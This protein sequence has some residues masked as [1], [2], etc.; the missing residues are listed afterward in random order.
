MTFSA[1]DIPYGFRRLRH[2][3]GFSLFSRMRATWST[4][5]QTVVTFGEAVTGN[6]F[7]VLGVRPPIT[8]RPRTSARGDSPHVASLVFAVQPYGHT[9]PLIRE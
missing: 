4:S 6:Y 8:R 5:G 7:T 1:S 9:V 3:R 2:A